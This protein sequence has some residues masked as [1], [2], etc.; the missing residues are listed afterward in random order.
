M[1][2]WRNVV[3]KIPVIG[4]LAGAIV[5]NPKEEETQRQFQAAKDAYNRQRVNQ[6]NSGMAA[7]GNE[8]AAF[9]PMNNL[10]GQ[11]YGQG[12]QIDMSKLVQNPFSESQQRGMYAD[13]FGNTAQNPYAIPTGA[14]S[15]E[16]DNLDIRSTQAERDRAA[17]LQRQAYR[18]PPPGPRPPA[19]YVPPDPNYLAS[20][21]YNFKG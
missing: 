9:A 12:S 1:G 3:S 15:T 7:F 16:Q 14:H 10:M 6:M 4:G 17:Q 8:A 21:N 5:G 18:P 2:D 13:A 20:Q 11:M 19:P